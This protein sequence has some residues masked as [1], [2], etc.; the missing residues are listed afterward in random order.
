MADTVGVCIVVS[1]NSPI[2]GYIILKEKL[3]KK[4]AK[5]AYFEFQ[6]APIGMK[7]HTNM[8]SDGIY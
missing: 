6:S 1:G 3:V 5:T 4:G 7:L 2:I 8:Y